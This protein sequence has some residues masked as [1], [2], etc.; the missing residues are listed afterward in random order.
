MRSLIKGKKREM[1]KLCITLILIAIIVLS[2]IAQILPQNQVQ[3]EYLRIHVR[4]NS[5]S[6]L[7]QSV[8][9]LVKNRVVEYLTP[10]IAECDTKQKAERMLKDNL[11][12]IESIASTTLKNS[13]FSYLAKASLKS[14]SF[15]TRTYKNLELIAGVYD[16][17]ILELGDAKGD[18]WWCVVYPPLCFV[19]EGQGVVY[20]SK[21][22]QVIS[23]FFEKKE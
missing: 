14:E 23:D 22:L 9:Y 12:A 15:P 2:G 8:K 21:I 11:S 1:K 10:Y 5:N 17:L 3:K 20:R 16:A 6:E 4:A 13:G 18:N 19:G 7:D